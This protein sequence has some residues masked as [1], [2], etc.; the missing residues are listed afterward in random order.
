MPEFVYR[1]DTAANLD[2]IR[3]ESFRARRW[4][5]APNKYPHKALLAATIEH[6]QSRVFRICFFSSLERALVC[7]ANDFAP[8]GGRSIVSRCEKA[9]IS[10]AEFNESWDDGF[11]Q[12]EAFLFWRV[13]DPDPSNVEFS[14]AFLPMAA[15]QTYN[16]GN[17]TSPTAARDRPAVPP[18]SPQVR[19]KPWWKVW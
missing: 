14:Q 4:I 5:A 18:L 2:L 1:V 11:N 16:N 17:W 3:D 7:Q 8:L 15:F 9:A 10:E 13:E 6:P 19:K 12:G